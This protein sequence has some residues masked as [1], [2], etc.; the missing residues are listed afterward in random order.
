M[1]LIPGKLLGEG[2]WAGILEAEAWQGKGVDWGE[3][4]APTCQ[5]S[6]GPRRGRDEGWS[7]ERWKGCLSRNPICQSFSKVLLSP[8][9]TRLSSS[10]A[11]GKPRAQRP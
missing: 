4:Q 9:V 6:V 2:V 3:R 5:V 7:G 1:K 8:G 10:P 11:K